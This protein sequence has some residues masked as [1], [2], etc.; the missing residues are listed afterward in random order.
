MTAP[1]F[2]PAAWRGDGFAPPLLS[3]DDFHA[4]SRAA[5]KQQLRELK[6]SPAFK[7]WERARASSGPALP[8]PRQLAALAC[9]LLALSWL[10]WAPVR[11]APSRAALP[12]P[13]PPADTLR[14]QAIRSTTQP[15][16][17]AQALQEQLRE[18]SSQLNAVQ[19]QLS[20][21][22]A[23][24]KRVQRETVASEAR[25]LAT[26][27]WLANPGAAS[28]SAALA[29]RGAA[30]Q[31]M[32]HEDAGE[33]RLAALE[34]RIS[35]TQLELTADEARLAALQRRVRQGE[36]EVM[37]GE[38]RLA[39]LNEWLGSAEQRHAAELG[40][41]PAVGAHAGR[42]VSSGVLSALLLLVLLDAL[43]ALAA[44]RVRGGRVVVKGLRWKVSGGKVWGRGSGSAG[45]S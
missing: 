2:R 17:Q 40:L 43:C 36:Q 20:E 45:W 39:V 41:E 28:D 44:S 10:L 26:N 11:P 15:N 29:E 18:H 37:V 21:R 34:A 22:S 6:A 1:D 24:L 7:A 12:A 23:E 3:R 30:L 33:A 19:R 31:R 4:R 13:T 14:L 8:R 35:S 38:A 27:E 42:G 5:T 16:S 9:G 25:L 32:Q